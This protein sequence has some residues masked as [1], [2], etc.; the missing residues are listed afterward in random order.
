MNLLVRQAPQGEFGTWDVP[1]LTGQDLPD[2]LPGLLQVLLEFCAP[3]LAC[4]YLHAD[5]CGIQAV[6]P[7]AQLDARVG[8]TH[9]GG[10]QQM[11]RVLLFYLRH[12]RALLY[13]KTKET[14][15]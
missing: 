2:L 11:R 1:H 3:R 14:L 8:L 4:P 15:I 12:G 13:T 5:D 6:E 10:P 7:A 9:D